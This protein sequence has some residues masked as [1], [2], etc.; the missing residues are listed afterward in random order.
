MRSSKVR[1]LVS[2]LALTSAMALISTSPAAASCWF[3]Y[4]GQQTA[5]ATDQYGLSSQVVFY[6]VED[7]SGA[8]GVSIHH[9]LYAE[10]L[11]GG[12][13][14]YWGTYA[15]NGLT[16][17]G[18]SCTDDLTNWNLQVIYRKN[19]LIYC[20]DHQSG[21]PSYTGADDGTRFKM[22]YIDCDGQA[23]RWRLFSEDVERMCVAGLSGDAT[24]R[25][26]AYAK[27]SPS[28]SRRVD[29]EYYNIKR[30]TPSE[31]WLSWSNSSG[32]ADTGNGYDMTEY[33]ADDVFIFED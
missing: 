8:G 3:L 25:V 6:T 2:A 23:N 5:G 18:H 21:W 32:C 11:S 10:D 22:T 30:Y 26:T 24:L 33:A 29:I 31:T 27:G 20:Y 17:N 16:F 19:G 13:Y 9:L 7:L 14:I 4:G 12:E 28:T 15:G 1:T